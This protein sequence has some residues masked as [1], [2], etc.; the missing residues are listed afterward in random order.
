MLPAAPVP[1]GCLGNFFN[2]DDFN[3][4]SQAQSCYDHCRAETGRDIHGWDS[5]DDGVTCESLPLGW[6]VWDGR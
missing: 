2:C 1:C 5:E 3:T 4:Q 6:Q